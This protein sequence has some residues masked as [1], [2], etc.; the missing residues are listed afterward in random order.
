MI[1]VDKLMTLV[2]FKTCA[3]CPRCVRKMLGGAPCLTAHTGDNTLQQRVVPIK[4]T[5]QL[6]AYEQ[7]TMCQQAEEQHFVAIAAPAGFGKFHF[8]T[9]FCGIARLAGGR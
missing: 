4:T 7:L 5:T 1:I 2:A 6:L 8:L 3:I 9:I